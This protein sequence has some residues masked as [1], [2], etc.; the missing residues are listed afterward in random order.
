MPP[1]AD[2]P[3]TRFTLVTAAGT[4][5]REVYGLTETVGM[6]DSG[7]TEEQE[8]ARGE[9]RGLLDELTGLA[10]AGGG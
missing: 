2:V 3:S 9:L 8:A 6:P 5:V 7:L 10:V 4:H 1:L